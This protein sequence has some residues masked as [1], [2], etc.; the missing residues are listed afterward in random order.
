MY[1]LLSIISCGLSLLPSQT[2]LAFSIL[3]LAFV[4]DS[5]R[6]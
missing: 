5:A 4:P 6:Q 2:Y 1:V 3:T